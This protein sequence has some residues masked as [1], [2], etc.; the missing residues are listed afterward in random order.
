MEQPNKVIIY[1]RVSSKKQVKV[2]NG[3]DSQEQ[4]CRAWSKAH[5]YT[6]ERVFREEGVSGADNDRPTFN[7]MLFFLC[8]TTDKYI[9]LVFDIN[10]IGRGIEPY[11][12]LKG[13]IKAL[14]HELQSVNMNIED[15]EESELLEGVTAL[16][17]GY[18][19]KK[20]AKRAKQGM[21]EN[22][23]Q[24]FWIFSP[25]T[26]Y[27]RSR[28]N[29]RV[30]LVR[31]EPT[32]THLQTALEGFASG[33]FPTQKSV[34]DYLK[35]WDLQTYYGK[36]IKPTLTFVKNL[37]TS[38]VY[39]GWFAYERWAI[40]Y[41]QWAIEPLI[42][43]ETYQR[44]Q[45]KLSGKK[46]VKPRKYNTEDEDFPLRRCV[47][48]AVCGEKLT[49]SR[50]KGKSGKRFAYYHC[51]KKGCP[52]CGKGIRPDVM[53]KDFEQILKNITPQQELL[54]LG[55]EAIKR[56][57]AEDVAGVIALNKNLEN[58]IKT[59]EKQAQTA[60][61]TLMNSSDNPD[62]AQM[63]KD[64]ISGLKREIAEL[65]QKRKTVGQGQMPLDI[66][67]GVMRDFISQPTMI[68]GMG[69]YYKKQGVLNLC[70]LGEIYYDREKKFRTPQMSPIFG[71]FDKNLGS[72]EEWRAQKDSNPQPSDP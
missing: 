50:P 24:G 66:A 52:M 15:S 62:V 10:R 38:E 63:C 68:W 1:C 65:E 59:K 19:R 23:K 46:S 42:S 67:L 60:L 39:T 21:V 30:Y 29:K 44:I 9:V 11:M 13:K 36:T 26:G 6:V 58:D 51:H 16:T 31:N 71:I 54:N 12:L 69:D 48:C 47:R 8:E 57:Y 70:F 22:A 17:A 56:V 34:L 25:P 45:D 4:A 43:I 61:D 55:I 18:E 27:I 53:H 14:G 35:Q 2:G 32:A 7:E 33:R 3:L 64:R 49:A 5:G 72:S 41:Q 40:P 20:S 37:L 28:E